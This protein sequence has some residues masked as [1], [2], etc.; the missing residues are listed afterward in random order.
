MSM[1]DQPFKV[2]GDEI[3]YRDE[4]FATIV[5]GQAFLGACSSSSQIDAINE[6]TSKYEM[7]LCPICE[8]LYSHEKD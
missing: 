1:K 8:V 7:A 2:I 3:L 5:K 4:V 6:L